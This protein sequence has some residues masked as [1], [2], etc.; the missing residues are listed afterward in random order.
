MASNEESRPVNLSP[1]F[2][3]Q[4]SSWANDQLNIGAPGSISLGLLFG[5]ATPQDCIVQSFELL[6][7]NAP[8]SVSGQDWCAAFE[9]WRAGA[10]TDAET[11]WLDLL[12]WFCFRPQS[13]GEL[14]SSDID[15]HTAYFSSPDKMA[16]ILHSPRAE[17]MSAEL[18]TNILRLP[19]TP[20]TYNRVSFQVGSAARDPVRRPKMDEETF[21]RAYAIAGEIDR[22]ERR[23]Q[24]KQKLRAFFFLRRH[25]L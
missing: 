3:V 22:A 11:T 15:F 6:T 4:F 2:L 17:T 16:M 10:G 25:R 1:R 20:E 18:Y 12:G 14:L 13:R 7:T 9:K 23:L 24:W 8:E 21:L 5:A 19:G